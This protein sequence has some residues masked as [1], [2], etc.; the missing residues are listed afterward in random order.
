[1]TVSNSKRHCLTVGEADPRSDKMTASSSLVLF[2]FLFFF[3]FK[4]LFTLPSDPSGP[5][6]N[7]QK[8]DNVLQTFWGD[9]PGMSIR[10]HRA[11]QWNTGGTRARLSWPGP[12][13]PARREPDNLQSS[14]QLFASSAQGLDI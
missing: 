9:V 3:F 6:I 13:V 4:A 12:G 1:M 5:G 8:A 14:L 10:F 7:P 2:L 11:R